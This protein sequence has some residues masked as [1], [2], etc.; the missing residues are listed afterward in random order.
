MASNE[1]LRQLVQAVVATAEIMGDQISGVAAAMMAEDL[2]GYPLPAV[3][4]ALTACRRETKGRL[5]LAAVLERIDDGHL[6][7]NEAWAAA[8]PAWDENNTVVWTGEVAEAWKV[9]RPLLAAGDKVAAR[10]AFVEAY[11]RALKAARAARLPARYVASLGR[12]VHARDA[13][14]RQAVADGLLAHEQVA[15]HL[16]SQEAPAIDA[17]RLLEGRVE[18][19]ATAP[20]SVRERLAE[21]QRALEEQ[22]P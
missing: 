2:A 21:V 15:Q 4:A 18:A 7:P 14:L 5:T 13:A 10:L 12:D 8:L 19:T 20:E 11:G 17:S 16:L 3:L 9:C 6:A 22:G 1:H